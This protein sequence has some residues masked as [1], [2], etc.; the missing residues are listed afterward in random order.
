MLKDPLG[1]KE[2]DITDVLVHED[3]ELDGVAYTCYFEE[4]VKGSDRCFG[5]AHKDSSDIYLF[6]IM[7]D[8]LDKNKSKSLLN[9][10]DMKD[11]DFLTS[12]VE[13]A[14]LIVDDTPMDI[15]NLTDLKEEITI[16]WGDFILT[17]Q[18]KDAFIYNKSLY[19]QYCERVLR[20][21]R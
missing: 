16:D 19:G 2:L 4:D 20:R 17:Y 11:T 9:G 13:E 3:I 12:L 7:A 18:S 21:N 15:K 14:K 6:Q 5:Y 10:L 1:Q 8:T